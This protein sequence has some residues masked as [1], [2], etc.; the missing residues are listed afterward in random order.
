MTL[1]EEYSRKMPTEI[2]LIYDI[3][4]EWLEEI[5]KENV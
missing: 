4:M 2:K 3:A 1:C 5:T